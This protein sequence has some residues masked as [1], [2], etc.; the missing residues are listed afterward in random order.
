M[1]P[2]QLPVELLAMIADIVSQEVNTSTDLYKELEHPQF[3]Y[4]G[5][6]SLSLTTRQFRNI[7]IPRLFSHI[8]CSQGT[9][10]SDL[11]RLRDVVRRNGALAKHI[12]CVSVSKV[13]IFNSLMLDAGKN[14]RLGH[15]QK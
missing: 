12:R 2:P 10:D 6:Y 14:T 11:V 3:V 8:V 5:G 15:V 7:C 4:T 13:M 9:S 1:A